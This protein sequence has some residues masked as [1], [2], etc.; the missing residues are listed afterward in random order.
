VTTS[1]INLVR[2]GAAVAALLL[3]LLS[4]GDAVVLALLLVVAAWRLAAL[5]VVPALVASAWRWGSTSLDALAGAQAVLGPAGTVGPARAAAASWIAAAAVVLASPASPPVG[6][7]R[8]RPDLVTLLVAGALGAAA[9]DV[10][11][12]PSLQGAWWVRAVATVVAIGLAVVVGRVRAPRE[13]L[14]DALAVVAGVVALIAAAGDAPSWAGTVDGSALRTAGLL[15]A[16]VIAATV[17]G[18]WALAAMGNREA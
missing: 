8:A 12:G 10:V 5:A 4:R 18:G 3:A 7:V 9:A 13:P 17:V 1:Q 14:L 16:A 2:T 15:A 11:A 6:D